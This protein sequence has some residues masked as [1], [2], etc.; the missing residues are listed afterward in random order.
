MIDGSLFFWLA[1]VGVLLLIGGLIVLAIYTWK[2]HG[3]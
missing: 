2:K 3:W 1:G